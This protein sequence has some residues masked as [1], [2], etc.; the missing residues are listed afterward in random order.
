MKYFILILLLLATCISFS[1]EIEVPE[2][3]KFKSDDDY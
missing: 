3:S 1:D 2:E